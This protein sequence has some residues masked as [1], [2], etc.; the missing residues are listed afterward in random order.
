MR[1]RYLKFKIKEFKF[2]FKLNIFYKFKYQERY[3]IY[4]AS[5]REKVNEE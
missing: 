3:L 2:K 4:L 5:E 1:I